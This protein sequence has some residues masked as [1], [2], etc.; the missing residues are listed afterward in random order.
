MD[1]IKINIGSGR[2]LI[3]GFINIDRV[4]IIDGNDKKIV[5]IVM[6]IENEELP[7]KENEVSQIIADNTLEHIGNLEFVLN[8]CYRV[9][10]KD[11]TLTGIVPVAGTS[12]DFRD[13]THKRHFTIDT[14]S[15]FTGSAQWNKRKP[16]HPKYADYGFKKWEMCSLEEKDDLIYFKMKPSK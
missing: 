10:K 4:Q 14:F 8:E 7:Y 12:Y 6:D 11:G 5:D 2:K 3:A 13:P 9:L 1:T 15:Y 16:S